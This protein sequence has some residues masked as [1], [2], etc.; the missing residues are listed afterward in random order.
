MKKRLTALVLAGV[1]TLTPALAAV[2]DYQ[3]ADK[4]P[5]V[6]EYP[7]Y[8]DVGENDWFYENA[9]LCYEVGLMTGTEAGFEPDK[10]LSEE[11]TAASLRELEDLVSTAGACRKW[12]Q[13]VWLM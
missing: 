7:G 2:T 3:V 10:T 4:F 13:D 11:E 9:K 12:D 5:A 8:P 6:A 1:L